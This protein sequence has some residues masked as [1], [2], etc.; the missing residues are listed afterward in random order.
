M[1]F[2]LSILLFVNIVFG[3]DKILATCSNTKAELLDLKKKTTKGYTKDSMTMDIVIKGKKVFAKSN[4]SESE[5]IYLGGNNP[6][7]LEKVASGHIV[8]YTYFEKEK[9][10]TIQKSYDLFGPIMV[11]MYLKCK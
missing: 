11:N 4:T 3:Y 2:I 1:K 8:L 9:I 5:L 10:L 7:F 6:Q